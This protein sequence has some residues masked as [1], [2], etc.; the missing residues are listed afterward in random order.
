[1]EQRGTAAKQKQ[2][3]VSSAQSMTFED[4]IAA[5][6][7]MERV[8]RLGRKAAA[9]NIPILIEGESGV[10]KEMVARAI[11]GGGARRGKP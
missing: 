3:K 2:A 11:Q 6:P 5:S 4:L 9:S 10:G 8:L 1:V 7:V